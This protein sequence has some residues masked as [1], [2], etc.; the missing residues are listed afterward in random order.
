ML[1][2]LRIY[3]LHPGK[4]AAMQERFKRVNRALFERH[5][6]EVVQAWRNP[7]DENVFVFLLTFPDRDARE[8]AWKAY[9]E[10]PDF[11]AQREEQKTIIAEI[12][13]HV[14]DPLDV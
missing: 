5:G 8:R 12:T 4:L 14:L 9:H 13:L 7:D 1:N 2:E 11:L 10:D 6:I 3:R